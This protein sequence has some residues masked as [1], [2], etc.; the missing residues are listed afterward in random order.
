MPRPGLPGFGV[1]HDIFDA[2]VHPCGCQTYFDV[3]LWR[4]LALVR[5]AEHMGVGTDA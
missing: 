2:R 1:H 5:C 4:S 3:A